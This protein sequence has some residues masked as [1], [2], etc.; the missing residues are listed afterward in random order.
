[1]RCA[2]WA[3]PRVGDAEFGTAYIAAVPRSARFV[4]KF[5]VVP[6]IPMNP[7]DENDDGAV[8]PSCVRSVL[9]ALVWRP[10]EMV[11]MV[12]PQYCHVCRGVIL[13]PD[14]NGAA[15]LKACGA[16]VLRGRGVSAVQA[17]LV[18]VHVGAK[19]VEN[20]ERVLCGDVTAIQMASLLGR[21][22]LAAGSC[23]PD[24]EL[25]VEGIQVGCADETESQSSSSWAF[26]SGPAATAA[27]AGAAQAALRATSATLARAATAATLAAT[28][29]TVTAQAA[30]ST[31][32]TAATAAAFRI[33]AAAAAPPDSSDNLR[34]GPRC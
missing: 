14:A 10:H 34:L 33:T 1:V 13:N 19:Y 32:T 24:D 31:V 3:S 25:R 5:D 17:L 27:T 30:A 26:P 4:N 9:Y 22:P 21:G 8:L 11:G 29:A 16:D 28:A 2:T 12:G 23:G 18:H 7:S 20:L 6:R 15:F